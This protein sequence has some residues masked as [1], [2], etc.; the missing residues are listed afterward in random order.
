MHETS[1]FAVLIFVIVGL[2]IFNAVSYYADKFIK[3]P[4]IIWMLLL[5]VGYGLLSRYSELSL[6]ELHLSPDIV[7][8]IFVP[9]L[10]FAAT[11]KICLFHFRK[12]VPAASLLG[13]V[14]IL[15]S[16]F[17]F[18]S[19]LH[20][21]FAIAWL[22]ALLF[23]VIMSATD[24]LAVGA[25]LHRNAKVSEDTKLL[26]EGES[27]LNDGFV[28][29]V[30]GA[31]VLILFGGELF[32]L[33]ESFGS[34]AIHVIGALF[35]GVVTARVTRWLIRF[36][37]EEYFALQTNLTI[38]LAFGSYLLAEHFG[39]SGILAVF[40]AALSFGYKPDPKTHQSDVR[41]HIWEYFEYIANAVLFFLLGASFIADVALASIPLWLLTICIGL[42]FITRLVSLAF[43]WPLV[44]RTALKLNTLDFWLMNLSGA[45]GAVSVAL[46][47]LLPTDFVY[48]TLFLELAFC[49][50]LFSLL[51][52][53]LITKWLLA[54]QS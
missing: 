6:P 39:F 12:I 2:V 23:G 24:P 8:F 29:T 42:L 22:P 19:V 32:S 27:I 15:I 45:R 13:S 10:I 38:A 28:V 47:L 20:Y 16:M 48:K 26:I 53:P 31:L 43:L 1:I 3:L 17:I 11:Q 14:G 30:F 7:L 37:H 35:I 36:W 41:G 34:L 25:L 5:G 21:G 40:A 50:V 33:A 9:L 18:A 46:I 49:M 51:V 4:S 44:A 54:K 52:Y